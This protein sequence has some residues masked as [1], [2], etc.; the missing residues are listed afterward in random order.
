MGV[1]Q[2]V[3]AVGLIIAFPQGNDFELL[4]LCRTF[5]F[6]IAVHATSVEMAI[7]AV[8][9]HLGPIGKTSVRFQYDEL[10]TGFLDFLHYLD[11]QPALASRSHAQH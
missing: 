5:Q 6:I 1:I 7:D 3:D 2:K 8:R 11:Q 10:F 9:L 4:L